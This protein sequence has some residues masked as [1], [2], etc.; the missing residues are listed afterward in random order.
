MVPSQEVLAAQEAMQRAALGVL[1]ISHETVSPLASI[2]SPE[3]D[4]CCTVA[5]TTVTTGMGL[6]PP[7]AALAQSIENAVGVFELTRM[8]AGE[9]A[10]QHCAEGALAAGKLPDGRPLRLNWQRLDADLEHEVRSHEQ[11]VSGTAL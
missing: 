4:G 11:L 3:P 1:T 7:N 2:G 9:Q 8:L 6:S 5:S 10:D